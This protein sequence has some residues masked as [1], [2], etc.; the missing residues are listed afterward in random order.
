MPA[1]SLDFFWGFVFEV[2]FEV[3]WINGGKLEI[4]QVSGLF[5]KS[6]EKVVLLNVPV[7]VHAKLLLVQGA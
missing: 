1:D 4:A 5:V 7:E 3:N 6:Q 2:D